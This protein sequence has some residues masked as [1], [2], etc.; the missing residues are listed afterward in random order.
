[1]SRTRTAFA[2][3]GEKLI[4][5]E[6]VIEDEEFKENSLSSYVTPAEDLIEYFYIFEAKPADH[7]NH[8]KI[9]IKLINKRKP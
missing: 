8:D 4:F 6:G 5:N 7:T 3:N 1:M 2:R 9:V